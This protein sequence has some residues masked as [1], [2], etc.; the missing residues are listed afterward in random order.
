MESFRISLEAVAPIFLLMI[1]GY[2]LKTAKFADKKT[3]NAINKLVFRVFLPVLLFYNVYKTEATQIFDLKQILFTVIGTVCV[4]VIGLITVFFI[5]KD[6]SKRGVMLQGFF[7]S[8]YAI[9]GMPL[10]SYIYGDGAGGISA[11]LLVVIIPVFNIL[12][13][14]GLEIFN[15]G[16][17]NLKKIARGIATNPLII[18]CML[19]LLFLLLDIN[20]PQFIETAVRDV[21]RVASPLAIITLGA[22]INISSIKGYIKENL[23]VVSTRLV[24]VPLVMLAIAANI[25]IRGEAFAC[26]IIVF[27]SPVAVSSFAMAQQMGG[28][29][30]LAAQ[31]VAISSALCVFTLFLWIFIYSS[32]G[33]L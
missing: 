27:G 19:G 30:N 26:L 23:I 33:I 31:I 22:S 16:E 10:I 12:A 3:F 21:S 6:N 1:L 17:I 8:N 15:G 13:V 29:E 2:L 24:W 4:F 18:G 11:L 20:L 5:T 14:I 9:L 28:D 7:R 32:L 25:G